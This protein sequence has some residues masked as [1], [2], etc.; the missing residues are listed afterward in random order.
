MLKTSNGDF[1]EII[2]YLSSY[3]SLMNLVFLSQYFNWH[4]NI[5]S[6]HNILKCNWNNLC[7]VSLS[8]KGGDRNFKNHLNF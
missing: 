7:G 3:I 6:L 1:Q 2:R 8:L 4:L 5:S